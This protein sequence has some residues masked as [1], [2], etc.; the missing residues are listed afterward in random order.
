MPHSLKKAIREKFE[1]PIYSDENNDN[2]L[3]V[4]K[5]SAIDMKIANLK[6]KIKL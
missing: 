3:L 4:W 6:F 1:M 5:Y 2:L